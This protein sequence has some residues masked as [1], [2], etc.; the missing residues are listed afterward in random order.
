MKFIYRTRVS[1]DKTMRANPTIVINDVRVNR[2][3]T[4]A[5]APTKLTIREIID[6]ETGE[7]TYD[8]MSEKVKFDD[9]AKAIFLS[10]IAD[11]GRLGTAARASGVTVDTIHRH[12]KADPKFGAL[13]GEAL[14]VYRDDL[15]A[16]HQDLV[17]N[18][19][20]K[21][22][23]DRDGRVIAETIEYPIQLIAM[24]LRKH[25]PDY[26]DKREVTNT[27][28]GGVLIAPAEMK[29]VEDWEN[30]F[31]PD[32]SVIEGEVTDVTDDKD[33]L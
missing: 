29:S 27:F 6:P 25:D 12:V 10:Q 18:G 24:E 13:M 2:Q 20:V 17:F 22:T 30:R 23:F 8:L 11:H 21:K 33:N 1:E 9:G 16:H 5:G 31:S 15:V 32:S 28:R 7:V 14:Q 26:R 3:A 19:V 4:L